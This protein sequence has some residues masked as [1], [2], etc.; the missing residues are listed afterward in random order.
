MGFGDFGS[1]G[2]VHWQI[3]YSDAP[4]APPDHLDYDNS[5][6]HPGNPNRDGRPPIGDGKGGRGLMRVTIRCNN[7]AEVRKMLA[8]AES[9]RE[10]APNS[11][12]VFLDVPIRPFRGSPPNPKNRNEW[13]V[14]VDW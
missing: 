10:A 4:G 2:S 13:E 14:G 8:D 5:K 1:N 9:R 12:E 6:I 7:P 3:A 11:S